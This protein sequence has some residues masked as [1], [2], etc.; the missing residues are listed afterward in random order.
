MK[1]P[2]SFYDGTIC[3]VSKK[4]KFA[5][6]AVFLPTDVWRLIIS[7]H[8]N[9]VLE[10]VG[11]NLAQL[12]IVCREWHGICSEIKVEL[13]EKV[14]FDRIFCMPDERDY[15]VNFDPDFLEA[16]NEYL[17][18]YGE[19][20][21]FTFVSHLPDNALALLKNHGKKLKKL[22]F[23]SSHFKAKDLSSMLAYASN[24]ESLTLLLPSQ[25]VLDVI[26]SCTQLKRLRTDAQFSLDRSPLGKIANLPCLE[27]LIVD[28]IIKDFTILSRLTTLTSLSLTGWEEGV[29]S[30]TTLQNLKKLYL[31]TEPPAGWDCISRLSN[32]ESLTYFDNYRDEWVLPEEFA[33]ICMLT[34][35]E[36][37]EL[38]CSLTV[39]A[40]QDLSK[41]Q[42]L[43]DLSL[44]FAFPIGNDI[45]NYV[46]SLTHLK[47]VEIDQIEPD[48][49]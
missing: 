40:M 33:P 27:E 39:D 22:E 48:L 20:P 9:H 36:T 47:N 30:L 34:N 28:N 17:V 21:S 42:R 8:L 3:S 45:Y 7:E 26:G 29:E 44:H 13:C 35:L 19:T 43:R 18:K 6:A 1:T 24:L 32:L 4:F 41:L 14:A 38:D 37:L 16:R 5:E 25:S 2:L 23:S 46:R 31:S 11:K 15:K 12:H 49:E 10:N